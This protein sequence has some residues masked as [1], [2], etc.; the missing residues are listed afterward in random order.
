MQHHSGGH[1]RNHTL[2]VDS[3]RARAFTVGKIMGQQHDVVARHDRGETVPAT[4]HAYAL[5]AGGAT[6]DVLQRSH[7]GRPVQRGRARLHTAGPISPAT[8]RVSAL[9]QR[10]R[11]RVAR[12]ARVAHSQ[13]QGR[14]QASRT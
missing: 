2:G 4:C 6:H 13:N 10:V 14:M 9:R 8:H 12:S 1:P 11:A 3:H 5:V 7:T